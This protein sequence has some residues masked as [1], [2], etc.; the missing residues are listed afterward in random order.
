MQIRLFLTVPIKF[1]EI[2]P[3]SFEMYDHVSERALHNS[4]RRWPFT[5]YNPV[6]TSAFGQSTY[7]LCV[8]QDGFERLVKTQQFHESPTSKVSF[9]AKNQDEYLTRT[10]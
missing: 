8:Q 3:A 9:L 6:S 10:S 1:Q 7:D 2:C 4:R 5:S